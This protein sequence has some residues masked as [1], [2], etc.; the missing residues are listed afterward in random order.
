MWQLGLFPFCMLL[1]RCSWRF[2]WDEGPL[3]LTIFFILWTFCFSFGSWVFVCSFWAP[4]HTCLLHYN[5][6]KADLGLVCYIF[7]CASLR[8]AIYASNL[9]SASASLSAIT[10]AVTLWIATWLTITWMPSDSNILAWFFIFL[11]NLYLSAAFEW[12]CLPSLRL[13]LKTSCYIISLKF[14]NSDVVNYYVL[15]SAYLWLCHWYESMC[16]VF[17]Y[18]YIYTSG[19]CFRHGLHILTELTKLASWM[20][21]YVHNQYIQFVHS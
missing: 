12:L 4:F 16:S 7:L 17:C 18:I 3:C 9:G 20:G 11:Y 19:A 2:W 14:N 6:M 21:I 10:T 13:F 5:W 15:L 1:F 8:L